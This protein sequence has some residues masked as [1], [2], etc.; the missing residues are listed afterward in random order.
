M[1]DERLIE[2]VR[3]KQCLWKV[4]TMSYKDL[5]LKENAWKEVAEEVIYFQTLNSIHLTRPV[6]QFLN[7]EM[8]PSYAHDATYATQPKPCVVL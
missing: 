2:A 7:R 5:R 6:H 3:A 8:C 4:T 1:T